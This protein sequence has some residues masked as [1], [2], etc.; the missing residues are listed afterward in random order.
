L[1]ALRGPRADEDEELLAS[2]D[3]GIEPVLAAFDFKG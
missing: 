3:N 2:L 1:T